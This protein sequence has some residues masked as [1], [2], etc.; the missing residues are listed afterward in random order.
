MPLNSSAIHTRC[1]N[2]LQLFSPSVGSPGA[3]GLGRDYILFF[4]T[5]QKQLPNSF[6]SESPLLLTAVNAAVPVALV[7]YVFWPVWCWAGMVLIFRTGRVRITEP[8]YTDKS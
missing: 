4:K 1:T 2:G 3:N 6:K 8:E 5:Y 7:W